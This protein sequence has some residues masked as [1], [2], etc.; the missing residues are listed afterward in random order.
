[1]LTFEEIFD[2]LYGNARHNEE[3][4]R[5]E[6]TAM[7]DFEWARWIN[8]RNERRPHLADPRL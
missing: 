5:D 4:A 1:M 8:Y 6:I 2:A 7:D 3:L